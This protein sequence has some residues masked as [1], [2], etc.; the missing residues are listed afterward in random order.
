[1][2]YPKQLLMKSLIVFFLLGSIYR[3]GFCQIKI[4]GPGCVTSGVVYQYNIFGN[5]ASQLSAQI[6]ITGGKIWGLN[7]S[8]QR[9]SAFRQV[10]VVWSNEDSVGLVNYSSA[11]G[12]TAKHIQITSLL[13]GGI[14]DSDMVF[15]NILIDSIPC[16]LRCSAASGGN[17]HPQYEY[18]WQRSFNNISWENIPGQEAQNLVFSSPAYETLYFRRKTTEHKSGSISYSNVA[19]IVITKP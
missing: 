16:S 9:D 6:C 14:I 19:L 8:C 13:N 12:N 4:N 15:Q 1:M 11:A 18:E 10:K 17:C 3:N 7:T 5:K 2:K